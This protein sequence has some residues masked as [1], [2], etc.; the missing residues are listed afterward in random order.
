MTYWIGAILG[1]C[2]I[3]L[4]MAARAHRARIRTAR[5]EAMRLGRPV[6]MPI[7][8]DSVAAL[9]E[10]AT[11]LVIIALG[12]FTLKICVA[13]YILQPVAYFTL[14]DLAGTLVLVGGYAS[15]LVAKSRYRMPDLRAQPEAVIEVD[16]APISRAPRQPGVPTPD[17]HVIELAFQP[18]RAAS[19]TP[20]SFALE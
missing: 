18:A 19:S 16:A 20:A 15:W 5:A 17:E 12:W 11:P 6:E 2:G 14:F 9:G 10:M 4:L 13:F 1:S 8:A 7:A 3:Y